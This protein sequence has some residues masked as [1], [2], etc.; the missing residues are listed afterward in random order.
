MNVGTIVTIG[1]DSD[2]LIE[3]KKYLRLDKKNY[4]FPLPFYADNQT[5]QRFD[6]LLR[7]YKSESEKRKIEFQIDIE[8]VWIVVR[9]YGFFISKD[10]EITNLSILKR[11][12]FL[13]DSPYFIQHK[14]TLFDYEFLFEDDKNT[15]GEFQFILIRIPKHFNY[16][17]S[18]EFQVIK[19]GECEKMRV[20][21]RPEWFKKIYNKAKRETHKRNRLRKIFSKEGV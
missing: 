7:F 16:H 2:F 12:K 10:K 8:R 18:S 20:Q 11:Y 17:V 6:E 15:A 1:K 3:G 9:D 4:T 19:N 21:D 14:E 5:A 13:I